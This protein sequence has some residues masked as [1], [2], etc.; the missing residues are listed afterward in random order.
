MRRYSRGDGGRRSA[1][2]VERLWFDES[3]AARV[4]RVA[5]APIAALYAAAVGTRRGL[6]NAGVLSAQPTAIPAVSVGNLTVGGTGKTPIAAWIA[7]ALRARGRRP[8]IVIRGYASGDEVAVHQV[9][10]PDVPVIAN[11]DRVAGIRTLV[12]REC[13][14]A[15]LDDAFQHR[16]AQRA[17]D[18]VLVS[19]D[20]W[21]TVRWPL[22]AGPWRESLHAL[23]RADMIL[24]TRKVAPQ[25]TVDRVGETIARAAP[26]R[27]CAVVSLQAGMLRT[28]AG[29][30]Q[31]LAL[32]RGERVCAV[33]GIAWPAAFI[34]QLEAAGAELD[35][36]LF[37]DHHEYTAAD[38]TAIQRQASTAD[39]VVC[40]LKDAVKLSRLWPR[41]A[42]PI[43]YVSQRVEFERG[44]EALYGALDAVH[45]V[46]PPQPS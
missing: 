20:T 45:R 41:E 40:T 2:L 27:P 33:A 36:V 46:D 39:A 15:V 4:G 34:A 16:R 25:A 19:S 42:K 38:V 26:G 43:W 3:I 10:N 11:P 9:L 31:P 22:P 1:E 28:M 17:L 12:E 7:S 37:P 35:A 5:L 18:I 30:T 21:P 8:G 13:D 6:Y 24:I 14:V 23:Q 44:V 32:L 29:A